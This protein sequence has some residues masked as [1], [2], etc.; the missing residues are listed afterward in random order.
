[1]QEVK[2]KHLFDIGKLVAI[3]QKITLISLKSFWEWCTTISTLVIGILLPTKIRKIDKLNKDIIKIGL[4]PI[5][6]GDYTVMDAFSFTLHKWEVKLT[7]TT[8]P[9]KLS[10]YKALAPRCGD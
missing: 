1:M 5:K 8:L 7:L 9:L 10:Y 6:F 4:I 2:L 3:N